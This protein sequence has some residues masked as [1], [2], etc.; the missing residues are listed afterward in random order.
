MVEQVV[1]AREKVCRID[2]GV[3]LDCVHWQHA[4]AYVACNG[5]DACL[6]M[7]IEYTDRVG[8]ER[9]FLYFSTV[10]SGSTALVRELTRRL[11]KSR[12]RDFFFFALPDMSKISFTEYFE[13]SRVESLAE[14]FFCR[15]CD[16][17]QLWLENAEG[18]FRVVSAALTVS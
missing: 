10:A 16:E 15:G 7:E 14:V 6:I 8:W 11:W 12:E 17:K 18:T 4:K 9:N 5:V 2:G 3:A 1:A 13:G